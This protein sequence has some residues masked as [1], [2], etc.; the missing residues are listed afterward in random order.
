MSNIKR[1]LILAALA[2]MPT[3]AHA[4]FVTFQCWN[5]TQ[6]FPCGDLVSTSLRVKIIE[7]PTLTISG[8]VAATQSGTWNVTNVSGTVSLPTGASTSANQ[9]T[10]IGHVDGLEGLL[11]GTLTVGTHAVSQSG[12]WTVQPGNTA[13]TTPWLTS[14][15]QGGNTAAVNASSQ[16]SVNC[17]NCSGSG[18]SH[19]DNAGFTP[20]T[21]N[22]VPIGGELDDVGTTNVSENSAGVARIT[23]A[24]A[25]HV[26]QQGT[27]TTDTEI[28]APSAQGDNQ[29]N[30]TSLGFLAN[31]NYMF[32]GTTWDRARGDATDG[33]LVNLGANNDVTVAGVSTLAEQQTQTT[34]LQLIDNLPN[35]IGSTTSGQ[36]GALILGAVTTSNPTYTTAQSH[37][38]SLATDGSLRVSG[39]GGGTQ[40]T[41]GDTDATVTGTAVMW[42]DT[43][44]TLRVASAAKPLPVTV[45]SVTATGQVDDAAFT[46]ATSEVTTIGCIE[47]TDTMD[48]GDAGAV[49]CG[50]DRELDID[51]MSLPALP[52][53]TN[54]IG[55][56]D[57]ASFP[58]NEPFNV[59]QVAGAT[60]QSGSGT[61]TGALRVELP[62][63]GTGTLATVSTVTTVTNLTNLPNEGQQTA[64]NSISV[65]PDTDND[66]IG[67]PAAAVPGE[68]IQVGGT[69]GTNLTV[70]YIDPCSREARTNFVVD[71]VTATTT[72]IANQVASEF[73]YICSVNLVIG[74]A[75]NVTIVEDDTDAC[76]SPTAAVIGGVTAAE[77]WNFAANG[78]IALP[79]T[80]FY[81]MRTN[82][83]NRFL[84]IITSAAVQVSG[85]ITY[86][87][88]P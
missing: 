53:G 68:A 10:L 43:S 42:E 77:G 5:G 63:N 45:A 29:S 14:I 22:M 46:V 39:G 67:A 23:A 32:D 35:T 62:T 58:D 51:V 16:L 59:A 55:D 81:H 28:T 36:S 70:P 31:F 88:A 66:A 75:N 30:A 27:V 49:K 80:G 72:E 3:T 17:A 24:R 76:A 6:A 11:G 60:A 87:S 21:T 40:Y 50:S 8:T 1:Y 56:V 41:E 4:Q 33:L 25:L 20:G 65:T 26:A 19:Q 2:L 12:T 7:A 86:V 52:A 83:A 78:G 85:N 15:S 79:A 54:N 57:V 44:D 73:F 84:C 37:P 61:A 47:A 34:A 48:A 9:T 71:I 38:L 69:D 13:N 18:V 82:T 64:A 74:G